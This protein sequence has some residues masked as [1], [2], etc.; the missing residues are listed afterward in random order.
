MT[1]IFILNMKL[2]RTAGYLSLTQIKNLNRGKQGVCLRYT[3]G[4]CVNHKV[5]VTRVLK[6]LRAQYT[7]NVVKRVNAGKQWIKKTA[8]TF[9]CRHRVSFVINLQ[10]NLLAVLCTRYKVMCFRGAF[11]HFVFDKTS[12]AFL[13][14]SQCLC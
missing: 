5:Q 7:V 10:H 11:M 3:R 4:V 2:L 12:L 13:C 6:A 8:D 1:H 14:R 9:Q